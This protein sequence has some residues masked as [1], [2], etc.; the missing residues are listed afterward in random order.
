MHRSIF[1]TTREHLHGLM[2][3]LKHQLT[4]WGIIPPPGEEEERTSLP[5]EQQDAR[6]TLKFHALPRPPRNI[7]G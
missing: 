3:T 4:Q 2:T 5:G 7:Q 6:T 1:V